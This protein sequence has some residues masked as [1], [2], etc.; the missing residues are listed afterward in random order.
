MADHLPDD[1]ILKNIGLT[2]L[3]TVIGWVFSLMVKKPRPESRADYARLAGQVQEIDE[4]L[5]R[6][7]G[8][9]QGRHAAGAD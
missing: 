4:R 3:G 8:L 9:L 5:A 7:E 6:I 1:G 2:F